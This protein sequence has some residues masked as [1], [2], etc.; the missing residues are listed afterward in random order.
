MK[1]ISPLIAAVL[2]IGFTMAIAGLMA[3]WATTFTK[4]KIEGFE[5]GCV[6][7]LDISSLSFSNEIV[8]VKIKNLGNL[9]LTGLTASIEYSDASK[10]TVYTLSN[11]GISDPFPSGGIEW[12]TLNT[13]D[14]TRPTKIEVLTTS[15]PENPAVLNF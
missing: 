4:T 11:Y 2:L 7:A 3:T 12:L 6:G 10:N 15:C 9:N 5:A 13:T 8:T 14:T 1:G